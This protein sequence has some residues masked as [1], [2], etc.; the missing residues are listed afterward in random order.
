VERK[1]AKSCGRST[2]ASWCHQ[3][4]IDT[5]ERCTRFVGACRYAPQGYRS[6]GPKRAVLYGGS[7]YI[8]KANETL[9]AIVQVE[10]ALGL[11]NVAEI[12]SVKNLDMIYI[13]PNDLALSLGRDIRV[14]LADPVLMKAIDEMAATKTAGFAAEYIAAM[15]TMRRRCSPRASSGNCDVRRRVVGRGCCGCRSEVPLVTVRSK[16]AAG[17]PA[18]HPRRAWFSIL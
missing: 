15:R 11:K 13:G 17:G 14:G 18:N 6:I 3:S 7:D 9:L 16:A 12:A 10:S 2:L 8:A 5:A 4:N 1:R